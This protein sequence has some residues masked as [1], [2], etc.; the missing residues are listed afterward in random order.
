M[1]ICMSQVPAV[2]LLLHNGVDA[3]T[4][5]HDELTILGMIT[6]PICLITIHLLQGFGVD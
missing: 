6:T 2:E 5:T 1:Y 3:K 4:K